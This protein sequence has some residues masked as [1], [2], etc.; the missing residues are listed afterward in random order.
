[1]DHGRYGPQGVLGGADGGVNTV[2]VWRDGRAHIPEHLS[3]E[4]DITL[5]AGDRVEVG[6]PGGGGYGDPFTRDP[7]LVAHDVALGY[8]CAS[9]AERLFGVVLADDGSVDEA[10][11][12][13]LRRRP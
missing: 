6:T 3:K 7:I 2:R 5:S 8:Y 13:G 12:E 9:D 10:A 11:T 1:M 4:Q